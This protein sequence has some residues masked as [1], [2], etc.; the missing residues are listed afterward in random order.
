M[1]HIVVEHKDG[2]DFL[3]S[4][5]DNSVNLIL[6]YPLYYF[7]RMPGMSGEDNDTGPKIEEV[8]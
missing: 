2:I 6:T 3:K 4:L 7:K 1:E 5:K 8:N